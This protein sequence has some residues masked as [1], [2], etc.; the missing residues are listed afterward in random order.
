MTEAFVAF[1]R[2]EEKLLLL[3]RN[4]STEHFPDLRVKW[5]PTT[6]CEALA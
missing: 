6:L 1:V 4:S 5:G 3:K 2:F